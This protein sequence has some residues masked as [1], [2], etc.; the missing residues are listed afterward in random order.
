M[1]WKGVLIDEEEP[2]QQGW[3]PVG[4][5]KHRPDVSEAWGGAVAATRG[6][7]WEHRELRPER[8]ARA[9]SEGPGTRT[10]ELSPD[11]GGQR[12]P[13]ELVKDQLLKITTRPPLTLPFVLLSSWTG[14]R[15]GSPTWCGT[16]TGNT[17]STSAGLWPR[18]ISLVRGHV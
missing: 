12:S 7:S 8:W 11:P 17:E 1:T 6:R 9:D 14:A 16:A 18:P 4:R 3:R 13:D 10:G 5:G 15:A 2:V